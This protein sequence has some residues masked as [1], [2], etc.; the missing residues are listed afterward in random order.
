MLI[1]KSQTLYLLI[2]KLVIA[3]EVINSPLVN[4]LFSHSP[5]DIVYTDLWTSPVYSIDGF[6][7]YVI[8]VDH[9]TKYIWFYSLKNK[10]YTRDIFIR[11]KALDEKYFVTPIRVL[12]SD[13]EGE[14]DALKSFF[15]I[16]DISHL[17]SPPHMLEH[18]VSPSHC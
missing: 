2:V 5:L 6:K 11:Y 8:F 15:T 17:T 3:I 4:Q 10:S 18:K 13:N 7:Y 12:Y 16:N 14:Y 9:H 1:Y